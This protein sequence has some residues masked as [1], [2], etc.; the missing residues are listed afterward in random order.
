MEFDEVA[1]D[2][3]TD[4]MWPVDQ[5]VNQVTP[6]IRGHHPF[7]RPVRGNWTKDSA[8]EWVSG[9]EDPRQWEVICEEC[10]DKGGPFSVQSETAKA[11]RGPYASKHKAEHAA[12]RHFRGGS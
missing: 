9:S 8:G 12:T 1:D 7:A 10:G 3:M 5:H 11:R 4:V 6:D 2:L